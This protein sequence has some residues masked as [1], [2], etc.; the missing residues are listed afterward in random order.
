MK[1]CRSVALTVLAAVSVAAGALWTGTA[2]APAL[3]SVLLHVGSVSS[4]V[5]LSH[6]SGAL[7]VGLNA[8]TNAIGK[9]AANSGVD[10]GD[11]DVLSIGAGDNNIGNVDVVTMPSTDPCQ[12]SSVAKTS[13][14]VDV[15]ADAELVALTASQ[16]I[17]VCGWA[18]SVGGTTPTY[19]L[20]YGT[21]TTCATG[22]TGLTGAYTGTS[23]QS[24]GG[25]ATVTK[26]AVSNALCIDVEGSSPTVKGVLTY[27]KQ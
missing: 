1:V 8:G 27:V 17:S 2:A 15:S 3:Q 7:A 20:I 21:G 24:H 22:L 14:A 5:A 4:P 10:I 26:T 6:S 25:A 12:A 18:V 16:V 9:L 23:F 13:V 19:R 11:V